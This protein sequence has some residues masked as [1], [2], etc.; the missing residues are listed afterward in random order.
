MSVDSE[1]GVSEAPA[2]VSHCLKC[3]QRL[4]GQFSM[5]L[6]M[7]GLVNVSNL[8]FKFQNL[9]Q[10]VH[11]WLLNR[12]TTWV[13]LKRPIALG[14]FFKASRFFFRGIPLLLIYQSFLS[15]FSEIVF[16]TTS[17]EASYFPVSS[18]LSSK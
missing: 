12:V 7:P 16:K 14:R 17:L 5:T 9:L 11:E 4:R 8:Q 3:P 15:F 10:A 18:C 6:Q 1:R 13:A 2:I